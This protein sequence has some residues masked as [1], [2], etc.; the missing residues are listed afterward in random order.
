MNKDRKKSI[1][2]IICLLLLA[3]FLFS[4]CNKKTSTD[5]PPTPNEPKKLVATPT[6]AE[7]IKC[8][9]VVVT[10]GETVELFTYQSDKLVR[11]DYRVAAR[12]EEKAI[13]LQVLS[14]G[15]WLH[16]WNQPHRYNND[17]VVNPPGKKVKLTS[18]PLKIIQTKIDEIVRLSG[19]NLSGDKLCK[20]WDDVDP[21][22]Q[23]PTDFEFTETDKVN[24][25]IQ[26]DL[27]KICQVCTKTTDE[28]VA[29]VCRQ[30]LS[31]L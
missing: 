25:M 26:N 11:F 27:E 18:Q 30:N 12:S 10:A 17:P 23:V 24:Q 2:L 20:V 14:D 15:E 5:K 6:P 16:A 4:S 19:P 8:Q 22:F 13:N 7:I 21:V 29:S 3:M 9:N 1:F 31:C 28:K